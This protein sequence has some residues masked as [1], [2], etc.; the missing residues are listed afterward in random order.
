M[1]P[2]RTDERSLG[3]LFA[4]LSRETGQLVRKEVELASTELTSKARTAAAGGGI[5]AAGGALVHAGLLVLLAAI[6]IGL[7]E[8]GVPPWLSAVLVAL[9]TMLVGYLLVNKGIGQV[10]RT[11]V[12][13]TQT[14]E[15]LKETA[16]WT[17]RQG[18]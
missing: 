5:A 2:D 15:T 1:T 16:Q 7:A 17:T 13:P 6:V 11:G 10:R 18:A 12:A 8:I 4:E 14:I 9:A 3:D